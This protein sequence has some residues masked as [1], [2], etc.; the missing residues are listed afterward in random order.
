[1]SARGASSNQHHCSTLFPHR[2]KLSAQRSVRASYGYGAAKADHLTECDLLDNDKLT[3]V[4][5]EVL[6]TCSSPS[7]S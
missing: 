2:Q 5:R 3:T 4:S 1:M 7:S 6:A